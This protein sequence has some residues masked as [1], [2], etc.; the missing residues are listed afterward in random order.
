MYY[1]L[2]YD[3]ETFNIYNTELKRVDKIPYAIGYNI[4]TSEG[5]VVDTKIYYIDINLIPEPS[6]VQVIDA[7]YDMISKFMKDIVEDACYYAVENHVINNIRTKINIFD[8]N[9]GA[10]DKHFIIPHI[11][12]KFDFKD[13]QLVTR[14][15]P[16]N[17]GTNLE[18]TQIVGRKSK[19]GEYNIDNIIYIKTTMRCKNLTVTI[20]WKDFIYMFRNTSLKNVTKYL[21]IGSTKTLF[22]YSFVSV[23]TL[24]YVGILPDYV[25]YK[26]HCTLEEYNALNDKLSDGLFNLKTETEIYLTQDIYILGMSIYKFRKIILTKFNVDIFESVSISGLSKR[27]FRKFISEQY[28]KDIIL[29][30]KAV[31]IKYLYDESMKYDNPYFNNSIEYNTDLIKFKQRY[32]DNDSRIYPMKSISPELAK[33]VRNAYFGGR[34]EVLKFFN[35]EPNTMN[36]YDVNSL[37]PYIMAN[38]NMP[39]NIVSNSSIESLNVNSARYKILKSI[40]NCYNDKYSYS[41]YIRRH[42]N[43]KNILEYFKNMRYLGFF[44]ITLKIQNHT[45]V[46]LPCIFRDKANNISY[47]SGT[48]AGIYSEI[49]IIATMIFNDAEILEIRN[50]EIFECHKSPFKD[51]VDEIYG[52]KLSLQKSNEPDMRAVPKIILNSLTGSLAIKVSRDIW[53]PEEEALHDDRFI[54]KINF[55]NKNII[56]INMDDLN[57]NIK[58]DFKNHINKI[59]EH[60]HVHIVAAITALSRFYIYYTIKT[61]INSHGVYYMDTDSIHTCEKLPDRIVSSDEIGKFKLENSNCNAIYI[62]RKKYI[63]FYED[64]HKIVKISG[65]VAKAR[66]KITIEDFKQILLGSDK[67]VSNNSKYKHHSGGIHECS[68]ICTIDKDLNSGRNLDPFL[69]NYSTMPGIVKI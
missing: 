45:E 41:M 37:Y 55:G 30:R 5:I 19:I 36:V 60:S 28:E 22:P 51:F 2:N 21:N 9:G 44:D 33:F 58:R 20:L 38:Y 29:I 8:F 34:V 15:K 66:E 62:G 50:V 3:T 64:G 46:L 52:W 65:L 54:S 4:C 68:E 56:N 49:D 18:Y 59:N 69:K 1:Y 10:F 31:A 12:T 35:K 67:I 26:E 7:S 14:N 17:Y 16:Q 24:S 32:I 39:S 53:V 11:Y 42:V 43:R 40:I 25:Y 61:C 63:L 57:P 13:I 27:I 6:F 48:L 47:P 23:G